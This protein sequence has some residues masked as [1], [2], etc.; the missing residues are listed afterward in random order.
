MIEGNRVRRREQVLGSNH[1]ESDGYPENAAKRASIKSAGYRR[2][3]PCSVERSR[4]N[5]ASRTRS[6][7]YRSVTAY[8][9]KQE[10]AADGG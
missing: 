10:K 6:T 7:G 2:V 4:E 9:R 1:L 5:R 3:Q 8:N